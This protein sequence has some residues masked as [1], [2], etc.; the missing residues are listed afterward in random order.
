[1]TI[2]NAKKA[3]SYKDGQ[4]RRYELTEGQNQFNDKVAALLVE[5]NKNDLTL[6]QQT[7]EAPQEPQQPEEAQGQSVFK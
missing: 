1:M 3:G 5:A 6:G 7:E 2:V 4:G